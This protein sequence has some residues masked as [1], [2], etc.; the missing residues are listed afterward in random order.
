MT[1]AMQFPLLVGLF[2][3]I[4]AIVDLRVR[5]IPNGLTV[6]AALM[7]LAYHTL[8]PQGQGIGFALA[9]FGVGFALLLLPWMLGGGGMGDVKLLAALGVW[10]GP[11]GILVAF[12]G[13]AVCGAVM[14]V[15]VIIGNMLQQGLMATRGKQLATSSVGS[16]S[17]DHESRL[18]QASK[19]QA[20]PFA[21]PLALSTWALLAWML[22]QSR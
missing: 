20:L 7:G 22:L 4:A 12:A 13:S 1:S 2:I 5:R 10:L 15:V 16:A 11:V 9:G 3:L 21:V 19:R 18:K 6:P 8:A 14:A 17:A